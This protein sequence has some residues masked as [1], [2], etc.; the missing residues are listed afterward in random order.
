MCI[1]FKCCPVTDSLL[2][3]GYQIMF[4]KDFFAPDK[5]TKWSFKLDTQRNKNLRKRVFKSKKLWPFNTTQS[6]MFLVLVFCEVNIC[7]YFRSVIIII[8]YVQTHNYLHLSFVYRIS[9]D[10]IILIYI[11]LLKCTNMST[12]LAV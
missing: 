12:L 9:R 7:I 5:L 10:P 11:R 2:F 3:H 4:S 1:V 6:Q 8:K